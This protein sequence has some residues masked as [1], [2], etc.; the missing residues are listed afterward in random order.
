MTGSGSGGV[1]ARRLDG[2]DDP[3]LGRDGW[4]HLVQ[5]SGSDIV[6]RTWEWQRAW[7][8]TFGTGELLLLAA[9]RDGDIVAL[10]PFYAE[11]GGIY[12]LGSNEEADNLDFIGATG[13]VEVLAALL[14][15]ARAAVPNFACFELHFLPERSAT[16]AALG[17]AAARHGLKLRQSWDLAAPAVDLAGL[18]EAALGS[19]V[20]RKSWLKR[21]RYFKSHGDLEVRHFRD[22]AAIRPHLEEFFAQHVERRARRAYR[23]PF[24]EQAGR[25]FFER[26]TTLAADTGWLRFTRIDWR[27]R[28]L[29]FHYGFCH[30]G[31]Y[32]WAEPTFDITLANRSPGQVLLR[33]L[34]LA[35][36]A[37]GAHTFDLG[38]NDQPFKLE[39]ATRIDRVHGY[40]LY[41]TT[42]GGA[43]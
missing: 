23:N 20:E 11:E 13:D 29:A 4:R 34:L 35:A 5:S 27:G 30:R 10:A 39:I 7:W 40:S 38:S 15:G 14:D 31:R 22:G 33:Q 18:D 36:A 41:P 43:P 26:L 24:G 16:L 25:H 12:F 6:Y 21:E 32:V 2:F 42:Q 28:P 17:P 9:E 1:Q 8:E 19:L 37:E 3:A